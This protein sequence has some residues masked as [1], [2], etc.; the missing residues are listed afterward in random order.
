MTKQKGIYH[1]DGRLIRDGDL[2]LNED[3]SVEMVEV[4][5]KGSTVAKKKYFVATTW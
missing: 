3:G 4:E 2:K 5:P 1:P